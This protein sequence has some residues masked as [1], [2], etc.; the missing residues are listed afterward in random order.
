M[1]TNYEAQI[2]EFNPAMEDFEGD[3]SGPMYEILVS[4]FIQW[5]DEYMDAGRAFATARNDV[6]VYNLAWFEGSPSVKLFPQ[7][8]EQATYFFRKGAWRASNGEA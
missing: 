3:P 2:A 7:Y 4:A 8:R 5:R 1:T 6:A